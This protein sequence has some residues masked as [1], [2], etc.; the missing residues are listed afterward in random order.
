MQREIRITTNVLLSNW[1]LLPKQKQ[2]IGFYSHNSDFFPY[3]SNFYIQEPFTFKIPK[4]CGVM[5]ND[6]VTVKY[7]EKA[8]MLCKA[9][10]MGDIET[11]QNIKKSENPTETK[12]LGRLVKPWNQELWDNNVCYIAKE[13]IY[14]KFNQNDEYKNGLLSTDNYLIAEAAPRDKIWGIGMGANN[15]DL[16]DPKKWKGSNIL[17]WAL[18]EVR[19]Q[20]K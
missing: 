17:G 11:Y 3:F 13:V 4:W 7:S 5:A 16:N 1:K 8:I 9:S 19:D 15:P 6:T 18:M 12:K 2:I 10:L 14:S 20:L